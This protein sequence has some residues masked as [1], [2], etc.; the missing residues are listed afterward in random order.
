M[1]RTDRWAFGLAAV[2]LLAGAAAAQPQELKA[3]AREVLERY[4]DA[5]VNVKIALKLKSMRNGQQM[6]SQDQ[7]LEVAG[8]IIDPSGLLVVAESETDPGGMM[9]AM[10]GGRMQGLDI[11]SEVGEVKI[12][13]KDGKEIAGR[14]V[15][16]DKDLDLAFI[17]PME[18]GLTFTHVALEK[19]KGPELFDDILLLGRLGRNLDRAPSVTADKI[20]AI[21]KKPRTF[22]VCADTLAALTGGFG[23]PAFDAQ[24]KPIGLLVMRRGPAISAS[25]GLSSAFSSMTPVVLPCEDIAEVARQALAEAAKAPEKKADEA[26]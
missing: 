11:E 18:K 4:Q 3:K 5:V 20:R 22:Y 13:L 8:T 19:G 7:Q 14:L 9:K 23:C 26:P 2:F 21:V 25:G 10:S 15:M 6:Q 16:R 1:V 12:I 24:G 17:A